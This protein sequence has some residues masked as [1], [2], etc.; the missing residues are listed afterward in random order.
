[1]GEVED[2][3]E[4]AAPQPSRRER[5]AVSRANFRREQQ[6]TE[7]AALENAFYVRCGARGTHFERRGL[8]LH[9]FH[10]FRS[11]CNWDEV[12][13]SVRTSIDE[14]NA[15]LRRK[16]ARFVARPG[17]G[18]LDLTGRKEADRMALD[19]AAALGIGLNGPI[20]LGVNGKRAYVTDWV[21]LTRFC[22][23][24]RAHQDAYTLMHS[25]PNLLAERGS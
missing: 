7:A 12:R 10:F 9:P 3:D 24:L 25:T 5:L 13:V 20:E 23:M 19:Y 15:N 17:L 16:A 4:G 11:V 8:R 18:P 1:L 6:H 2:Q 21:K 22:G 14:F